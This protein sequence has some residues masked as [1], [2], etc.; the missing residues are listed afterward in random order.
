MIIALNLLNSINIFNSCFKFFF[1]KTKIIINEKRNSNDII[2]YMLSIKFFSN[3]YYV[4]QEVFINK[5][6]V[7]ILKTEIV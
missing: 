3:I 6:E 4:F 2:A 7:D 1:I 5:E